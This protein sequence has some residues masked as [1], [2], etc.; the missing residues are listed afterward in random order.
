MGVLDIRMPGISGI[1]LL[2]EIKAVQ[3]S[4]EAIMLT[5]QATVDSAI[6]T[7]KL[8][9]YDYL[10]KPCKLF[11]LEIIIRKAYEKKMLAEQNV[12]LQE[13]LSR[14]EDKRTLIGSSQAMRELRGKVEKVAKTDEPVLI[15]GEPGAGKEITALAIHRASRRHSQPFVTV[16]CGVLSE[17]TLESE[18]FGHE[19]NAFVGATYMKRGL[20][21]SS[22][23]GTVLLDEVE[24]MSP[25]MQVK[26][27]HFLDTS[28]FRRIGGYGDIAANTRL[29]FA[30]TE[31]LHKLAQAGKFREDFYYKIS[32]LSLSTPRCAN[33]RR[34]SGR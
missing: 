25:A 20:I 4:F 15:T 17:G 34:T 33:A 1:D 18:L 30:T 11:E 16:N 2:R 27:L 8:G 31:D 6:E 28:E 5:G 10:A 21:E 9:A 14:H 3:P 32:T 19:A 12:K 23:G 26:I 24:Q 7:M 22:A 29:I 13:Q